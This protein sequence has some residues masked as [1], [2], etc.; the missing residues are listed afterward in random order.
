MT[1][2]RTQSAIESC[3]NVAVGFGLA[4]LTQI[5][6]FPWFDLHPSHGEN[7]AITCIFTVVSL[8]RSYVLRRAFNSGHR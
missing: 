1:Q 6:A 3:T 7:V 4:L 5:I 2:T 8:A